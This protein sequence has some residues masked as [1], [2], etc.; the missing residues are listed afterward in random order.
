VEDSKVTDI[1]EP[2]NWK[3]LFLP[4]YYLDISY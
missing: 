2:L 1:A 4:F 3:S